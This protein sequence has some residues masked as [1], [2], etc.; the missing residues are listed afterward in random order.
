M[1]FILPKQTHINIFN[2][3]QFKHMEN[4]TRWT[5]RRPFR[6]AVVLHWLTNEHLAWASAQLF[7]MSKRNQHENIPDTLRFVL[8]PL[9]QKSI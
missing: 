6:N 1:F 3:K 2:T 8:F 7:A 4:I 5:T 9:S